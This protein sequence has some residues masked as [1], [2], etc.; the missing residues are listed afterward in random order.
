M[1]KIT[2]FIINL[3]TFALCNSAIAGTP[4]KFEFVRDYIKALGELKSSFVDS[5]SVLNLIYE[6]EI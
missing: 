2:I 4:G 5:T 1:K 6:N 3:I